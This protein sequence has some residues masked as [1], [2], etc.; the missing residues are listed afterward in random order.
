[1]KLAVTG[2]GGGGKT[3]I[4]CLLARELTRRGRAVIAIDADPNTCLAAS[5]GCPNAAQIEP[6]VKLKDLIEER[7]GAK[8]GATGGMFLLNPFVA[9]IPEKYA[10]EKDGVKVLVAGGI[11]NGGAGCYC[12]ENS[13]LRALV[14][15]LL[16]ERDTDLVLDMEAGI[17]HLSRGTVGS[18]DSLLVVVEPSRRS[19][20]TA[21]RIRELAGQLGLRRVFAVGNKIRTEEERRLLAESLAGWEFASHVPFDDGVRNAE[22]AGRPVADGAGTTTIAAVARLTDFLAAR[23]VAGKS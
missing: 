13:L 10:T 11:K 7:T 18:V 1:M 5:M 8:P 15:H 4:S 21:V 22:M 16:V 12:P 14:S 2:K 20:E 3:T 6:L 9:D 17:E 19:I 23:Q